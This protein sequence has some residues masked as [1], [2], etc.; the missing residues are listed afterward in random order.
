M[1]RRLHACMIRQVQEGQSGS[2]ST[3]KEDQACVHHT[4]RKHIPPAL[5]PCSS[6]P[7]GRKSL[8]PEAVSVCV[9][10]I[11]CGT[12]VGQASTGGSTPPDVHGR[13]KQSRWRADQ[14]RASAG[15]ATTATTSTPRLSLSHRALW[16]QLGI[17]VK[18]GQRQALAPGTWPAT[19]RAGKTTAAA[20]AKNTDM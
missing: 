5:T 14:L 10:G 19:A 11:E 16:R 7:Q 1:Q 2:V 9:N 17:A 3:S 12:Q 18:Q 8:P 6:A 13:R 4:A 15:Q 20:A